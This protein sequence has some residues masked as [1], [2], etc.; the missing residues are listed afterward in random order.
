MNSLVYNSVKFTSKLR[1]PYG[2]ARNS[3]FYLQLKDLIEVEED[4]VGT[5][6]KGKLAENYPLSR[7]VNGRFVSPWTKDTIKKP[8]VALKY[9]FTRKEQRLQLPGN[10]DSTTTIPAVELDKHKIS[11]TTVPHFTW[12]G[13]AS[14]YYQTDG[15]YFLTDPVFS[16]RA[17][18]SQYIGPKR[19][20]SP[21]VEVEDLTIDVVLLSHTHYDHLD[22][23]TA[24]RI[25]NRA[26]W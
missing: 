3:R 2:V 11:N 4:D 6:T 13:H 18:F 22:Y 9:L 8:S 7:K 21:A 10:V 17:S 12:L 1:L 15:V 24:C 14:C 5:F 16:E 26:L 25:G 19:F 20:Q 23:G